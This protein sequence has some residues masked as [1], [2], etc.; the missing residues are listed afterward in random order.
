VPVVI[1]RVEED[2]EITLR[3]DGHLV[4]DDVEE[5]LRACEGL[6]ELKTLDLGGLLFVDR[7]GTGALREIQA[8]GVTLRGASPFIRLLLGRRETND[9]PS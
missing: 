1:T 4:G 3:V 2:R 5:L 7:R 6:R 9:D 8:R